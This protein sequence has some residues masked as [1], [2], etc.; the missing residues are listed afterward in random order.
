VAGFGPPPAAGLHGTLENVR[1]LLAAGRFME[2]ADV[3]GGALPAAVA[4]HGEGSPVVLNLRKQYAST[5]VDTGQYARALPEI[6]L[7]LRDLQ[8]QLGPYDPVVV[9][10][11]QDEALC[12]QHLR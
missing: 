7:L 10:L 5:L 6:R 9:Q 3:L 1:R 12:V 8:P 2:V 11:R 4:E